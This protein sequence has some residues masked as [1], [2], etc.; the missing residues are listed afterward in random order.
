M[1]LLRWL[2]F[3]RKLKS[4]RSL[5]VAGGTPRLMFSA[6]F[7]H[8]SAVEDNKRL[9][10]RPFAENKEQMRGHQRVSASCSYIGNLMHSMTWV[11]R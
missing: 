9:S 11:T 3:A 2:G 1:K 8:G 6:A 7:N 10:S 5:S 4:R